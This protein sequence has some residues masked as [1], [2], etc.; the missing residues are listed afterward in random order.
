MNVLC[1]FVVSSSSSSLS[2]SFACFFFPLK[3][4][5]HMILQNCCSKKKHFLLFLPIITVTTCF[6]KDMNVNK[7]EFTHNLPIQWY[8]AGLNKHKLSFCVLRR[9]ELF[10]REGVALVPQSRIGT[11]RE[12]WSQRSISRNVLLITAACVR[13]ELCFLETLRS[14]AHSQ[15]FNQAFKGGRKLDFGPFSSCNFS[16]PLFRL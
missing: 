13:A 12:R 9:R 10:M 6:I 1:L 3:I 4:Q 14:S 11:G 5:W 2:S 15:G 7:Q 16:L 8:K